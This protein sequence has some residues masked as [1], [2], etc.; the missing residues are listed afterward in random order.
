MAQIRF[1]ALAA[2][3]STAAAIPTRTPALEVWATEHGHDVHHGAMPLEAL[4][5]ASSVLAIV[6]WHR[7]RSCY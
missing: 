7:A 4:I 1:N 2:Q 3:A 5:A 6:A